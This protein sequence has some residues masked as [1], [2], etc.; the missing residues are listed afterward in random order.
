[1]TLEATKCWFIWKERCLGVFENKGRRTL[2][3]LA[4]DITRHY[5]YWHQETTNLNIAISSNPQISNI[6]W[7]LPAVNT[8]KLNCD[9]SWLSESTNAGFGFILCNWTGTFQ[10]AAMGSCGTFSVDEVEDVA[11]LRATQWS[12][13]HKIQHLVIEGD[14]QVTTNYLQGKEA[15]VQWQC[16]AILEEVK[17]LADQL[18]Y[19]LGFH[20]V[21]RREIKVADLLAKKGRNTSTTV[22]WNDQSPSFLIPSIS[23]DNVKA[24]DICTLNNNISVVSPADVNPRDSVIERATQHELVSEE[25]ESAD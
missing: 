17:I 3:Q 13:R 24:Y 20:H 21:D 16:L 23:F 6:R 15:T 25:T 19:F 1:M 2:E 12:F 8:N 18:F 9:A 22:S 4:L 5:A 11:L 7:S 14:N 10:D